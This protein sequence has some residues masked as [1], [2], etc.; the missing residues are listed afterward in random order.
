MPETADLDRFREAQDRVY[1]R[2]L[3]EL[4]AG[5]KRSHWIWFVFPQIAGL[6]R[7]RTAQRYALAS[8]AEARMYLEDPTLGNRL[9]ECTE[10]VLGI[11]GRS[12]SAIFGYP[13]DLKFRSCMT[14]FDLVAPD[15][16]FRAAL[17]KYCDGDPD[18][19]TLEI[20]KSRRE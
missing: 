13:D 14:L 18:P 15:D 11:D 10:I 16:V 9:R 5:S 20:V 19:L 7:S 3:E 12:L 8:V 17:D 4:R 6:G 1:A 2:V